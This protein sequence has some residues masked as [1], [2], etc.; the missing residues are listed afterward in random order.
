MHWYGVLCHYVFRHQCETLLAVT[1]D[2]VLQSSLI[3][4]RSLGTADKKSSRSK[5]VH[6]HKM[7]TY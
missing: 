2:A 5:G 7:Q 1:R 3:A 6:A 4:A